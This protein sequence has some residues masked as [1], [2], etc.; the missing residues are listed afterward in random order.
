MG[1]V[2]APQGEQPVKVKRLKEDAILP[3]YQSDGAAGL[4]LH[5]CINESDLFV[6]AGETVIVPTGIAVAIPKGYV[7]LI[8]DRGS[9]AKD[10]FHTVAGV[11]DSDYRGEIMVLQYNRCRYPNYI[12]KGA[13]IAQML[14]VPCT[15]VEIEEGELDETE[16]GEG[17]FGS[18]GK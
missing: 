15:Q 1:E 11:V 14:I 3:R 13:R 17:R 4:D 12:S 16:R 9:M 18:T 5:A 2:E 10:G 7:G 6:P 8:W